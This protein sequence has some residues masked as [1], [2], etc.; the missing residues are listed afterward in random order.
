MD[1]INE[2]RL[3]FKTVLSDLINVPRMMTFIHKL[4]HKICQQNEFFCEDVLSSKH[5]NDT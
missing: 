1:F 2:A 3:F 4:G 5:R